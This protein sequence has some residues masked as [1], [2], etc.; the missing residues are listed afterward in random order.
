[1][2]KIIFVTGGDGLLGSNLVRHLLARGEAVRVMLQPG[3]RV[4]TLDG[5][6]IER[7]EADL[8][9]PEAV[10]RAMAGCDRVIHIAALTNVW[11]SRGPLYHQIN[12]E[13]TR[14]VVAAALAHGVTRFIHVGSAASFQYGTRELPGDETRPNPRSPYGLDYIDT[15]TRGQEV[16][17]QA[18]AEQGLPALVVNPTFMIGA[19]DSKPSSGAMLIGI[20]QR[21]TPGY[22]PGGK[23]WVYVGDAATAICNA[24]TMGRIGACYILG[25]E[26]LSYADAFRRIS[27]AMQVPFPSIAVPKPVILA[28]GAIGSLIGRI[29]GKTPVLTWPMARI[30]CDGHY[31]SPAKAVRELQMPQ[32]PIEVAVQEASDWFRANGYLA[33]TAEVPLPV[34]DLQV[35]QR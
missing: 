30:A 3:R 18:V 26:N 15:K 11:P 24:L 34:P 23:N 20:A 4:Q 9:D 5:L 27:A 21:K 12:V 17:L 16:V 32:T 14:H 28:A 35:E 19:Y 1:V 25:H 6:D 22:S 33:A 13:G 10:T 31:F 29:T 7:V 2:G 8:L